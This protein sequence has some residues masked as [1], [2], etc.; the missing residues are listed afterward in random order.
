M[1]R[2]RSISVAITLRVM[3]FFTPKIGRGGTISRTALAAGFATKPA[4]SAVRLISELSFIT[5]LSLWRGFITRSV[6]TTL[7]LAAMLDGRALAVW[8]D[9]DFITHAQDVW[10]DFPIGSNPSQLLQL[11]FNNVYAAT[12][13]SLEVGIPGSSG[14]SMLFTGAT[15]VLTYLPA[16]GSIG[17]LTA[18]VVNPNASNTGE[19]GGEVVA[20]ALNV[21][22]SDAGVLQGN[23]GV[24][25]GD[26]QIHSLSTTTGLNGSTIREF[27]EQANAMLGGASGLYGIVE[28]ANLVESMNGSF[29]LGGVTN[30]ARDHLRLPPFVT[31]DFTTHTQASWG[32]APSGGNAAALLS[33]NYS[34]VYAGT[35]GVFEVGT[36][37]FIGNSAQFT[38]AGPLLSYLPASGADGPLGADYVNPTT[39]NAGGFGGEIAALKLNID[40]ADEGLL[41]TLGIAFGD[42]VFHDLAPIIQGSYNYNFNGFTVKDF[43]DVAN[44]WLGFDGDFGLIPHFNLLAE[45]LNAAFAAGA[46]SPWSLDH[47]EVVDLVGDFNHNGTIDAADYVVWRK[48]AGVAPSPVNYRRWENNFGA[49]C[50]ASSG[51]NTGGVSGTQTN[52]PEPGT[53]VLALVVTLWIVSY[54]RHPAAFSTRLEAACTAACTGE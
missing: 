18:D 49:A 45:Q 5:K 28:I 50:A 16:V 19:F 2:R 27:Q 22:F 44:G 8:Q 17:Q 54:K 53:A 46:P 40:F 23:L 15:E 47:L 48:G 21:D 3:K 14:Y 24:P 7:V 9:G 37:G 13:A 35:G 38:G 39:T 20:L 30:F 43:Y 34:A 26:L 33:A 52:V 32:E 1:P 51:G 42:L 6:M 36:S 12:S 31:G 25:F 41:G 4:A 10:G 11:H 29:G